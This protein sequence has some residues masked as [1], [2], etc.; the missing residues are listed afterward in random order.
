MDIKKLAQSFL[1]SLFLLLIQIFYIKFFGIKNLLI[2]VMLGVASIALLRRDFTG[3]L[4]YRTITFL[5]MNLILGIVSYL[6]SLNIYV[7]CIL[8]FLTIF[9]TTY[10][11][12]ND[13]RQPTSYIFL[14]T[15]IFMWSIQIRFAELP[16]RLL[17]ITF[18]VFLIMLFQVLFNMKKF[19]TKSNQIV[20]AIINDMNNNIDSLMKGDY[21]ENKS[22]KTN[23]KI[24]NLM[25]FISNRS[26][27]KIRNKDYELD[28]FN[29]GMCLFRLNLI[30]NHI[31]KSNLDKN[32]KHEYL[33][34]LKKQL[35]N[36]D[37]FNNGQMNIK[38][39]T[40]SIG[41]LLEKYEKERKSV[42]YIDES[43]YILKI[44]IEKIN[45]LPIYE[46]SI[47][48][49]LYITVNKFSSFSLF[50]N[51]I[52]NFSF[53]SLRFK[54]SL[55][56]SVAL[57]ISMLFVNMTIGLK[58]ATWIILSIYVI[59]QPYKED[60]LSKAKQRF[61]GVIIGAITFYLFFSIFKDY[62]PINII[63]LISFTGYFYFVD[64][65][66]KVIM[67][68]IISLSS[69]SLVQNIEINSF[70]RFAFVSIGIFIALIFNKY[71]LPYNINDSIK[72]LKYKYIKTT[73][74]I[75]KEIEFIIQGNGDLDKVAKL[76][77]Q[78][79][80]IENKLILNSNKFNQYQIEKFIYE[81]SIKMNDEKFLIIK[82]LKV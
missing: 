31:Y 49:I 41:E 79:N 78:K 4:L 59:L 46:S 77:M 54:Y 28:K 39:I 5:T 69:I 74:D 81:E 1:K 43:L 12:M 6:S 48:N 50:E 13:F 38:D 56:L 44:F 30:I 64:Y 61:I 22:I 3:N 19:K 75:L 25:I 55:R 47:L 82:S 67:T 33:S 76:S 57:S 21:E 42:K 2:G 62:I 20:T 58:N 45:N 24:R 26:H 32:K 8:N 73:K 18:G 17:S 80:Q 11:Y 72:E 65:K 51:I 40:L 63:M 36:L 68:T 10:V 34:D 35:I 66:K 23:Q 15:Y 37:M 52:E 7:G 9:I 27:K 14:M 29:L 16:L 53:K 71:F 60:S 70:N